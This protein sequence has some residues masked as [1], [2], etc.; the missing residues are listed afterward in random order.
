[1]T[2]ERWAQQIIEKELDCK[3]VVHDDRAASRA[4]TTCALELSK[5]LTW[6]SNVSAQWILFAQRPGMSVQVEGIFALE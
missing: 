6:L 2:V 4:C 5:P 3:V 1:V